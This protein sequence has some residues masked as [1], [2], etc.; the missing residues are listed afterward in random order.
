MY[1]QAQSEERGVGILCVCV[2]SQA[3]VAHSFIAYTV[4]RINRSI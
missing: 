1:M 3:E 4:Y 2:F